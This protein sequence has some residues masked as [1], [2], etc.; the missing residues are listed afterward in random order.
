MTLPDLPLRLLAVPL[1]CGL[2]WGCGAERTSDLGAWTLQPNDVTLTEDLRVSETEA[3][4]FGG[5]ADV[6]VR[7]DGQIAV[8][9]Y[10]ANDVKV[11]TP[12]GALAHRL[13]QEGQ[14]PG[15]FQ[16]VGVVQWARGDSLF[17]Y[18][19]AASRLTVFAPDP[20]HPRARTVSV[21]REDGFP[22]H[23]YVTDPRLIVEISS[24]VPP[25]D[26]DPRY[27]RV[28]SLS[29]DGVPGDTLFTARRE[30][31]VVIRNDGVFQFRPLP[32]ARESRIALGPTGRLYAGYEDSLQV[33]AHEWNGAST[34]I[35]DVPAP[36]VSL[37]DADRDSALADIENSQMRQAVATALPETKPA[38][39]DLVVAD[40][41]QL[42]VRRPP[43]DPT[44]ET[45]AWWVLAPETKTIR[46]VQLPREVDIEVVRKGKAYGTTTTDV[47]AP[48]L[49]RYYIETGS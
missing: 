32:F 38:F 14:A 11:L 28:R 8:A 25:S 17:A 19:L 15:E 10:K 9:D 46:T 1:L 47:G 2:L 41:G 29:E 18:D 4:Y 49:V 24:R 6:A 48:A 35:A 36:P 3:F 22:T 45:T 44:A 20:P 7:G 42:W 13:G 27:R 5:L 23:V 34:V 21:S 43:E 12:D 16:R 40:D 30:Q 39:T 31:S 37:T 33:V 26:G